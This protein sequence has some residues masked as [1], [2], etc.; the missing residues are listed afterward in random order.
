VFD[1]NGGRAD[2]QRKQREPAEPEGEGERR[3]SDEAVGALRAQHVA[4]VRVAGRDD[5]AMKMHRAFRLARGAGRE[6]DQGD[7]VARGV[8][9]SKVGIAG[10]I[11]QVFERAFPTL[12]PEDDA[13]ER[14]RE[15]TRLL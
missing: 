12:P 6:R 3:D 2:A 8:A 7:I 9:G 14:G 5:V 15:R 11:H 13:V 10:L 1:Q 4:T